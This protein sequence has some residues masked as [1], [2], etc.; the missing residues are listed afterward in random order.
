MGKILVIKSLAAS[1]LT[2][3]L[4]PL[5]TNHEIIREINDLFYSY[6]WNNK[7]DKIK[8]SV[9]ISEYEKGGL[10]MVD[11]AT[12]NKSLKTTWIKNISMALTTGNGKNFSIL[13]CENTE[14]N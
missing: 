14:E 1:Q 12:F 3:I 10:K 11:I 2:Y 7:G 8:R 9:I 4:A 13:N 5:A 6:L